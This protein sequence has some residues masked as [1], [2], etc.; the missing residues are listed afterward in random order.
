LAGNPVSLALITNGTGQN[1][2]KPKSRRDCYGDL[3][4]ESVPCGLEKQ[5][6]YVRW[7]YL[8]FVSRIKSLTI[9]AVILPNFAAI[10]GNV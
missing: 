3:L 10:A 1:S 6:A 8:N 5:E 4:L 9:A 2:F 7:R